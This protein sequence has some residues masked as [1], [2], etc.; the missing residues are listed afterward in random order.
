MIRSLLN[1]K[2]LPVLMALMLSVSGWSQGNFRQGVKQGQIKVK[3]A[4]DMSSTLSQTTVN[5]RTGGFTTGIQALDQVARNTRARTMYRLFPY[6]PRFEHKLRKHGL[7]LW[8]IVE[9]DESVD[10]RT[11]VAQF[12]QLHEVTLAEVEHEK[13]LAPYTVKAYTPGTSTLSALPFNDPLLKDQWHYNNIG[14][15][16]FSDAD[17][18]LFEAWQQTTGA[19]NIVVSVHDEGVDVNHADLKAN[20]W[21]NTAELNGQPGV[22]DDGNGYKDDINGYNFEKN[23]GAIDAQ[24][25]GTHVAGTIAAVNNNGLGVSGVAGGNGTGNGVKIMSLQILGGAPIERSY[26]YAAN[27]GAVISQNSWGYTVPGYF[28]ESVKEAID[29]FIAEAGDY[30]GSPMRGGIVLFAAGNSDYDADWYPGYYESTFTIA[31][32]GPEWKRAYYSNYGSWVEL[33]APG[34]DQE[35]GTKNGVLSTIP[36]DQYAYLQGTSMACPHVSGIAALALANRTKQL[37]NTE[38]WNKL[39]TGV[40]SIDAYNPDYLGKLGAGAIDAALAIR[41]DAGMA[42]AAIENLE[43]AGIAQ[44]FAQLAWSVPA[45]EDDGTPLSFTIHY[46]TQPLT[47]SNLNTATRIQLN[48]TSSVGARIEYELGNLLGLT[49]YYFAVTA[50]DR[51]GNTSLISNVATATT[52]EGPSLVLQEDSREINFEIDASVNTQAQALITIRN[53]AA[54]ILRWNHFMRHKNATAAFAA[55]LQYPVVT[56]SNKQPNVG[57]I[58]VRTQSED[59]TPAVTTTSFNPLEKSLASWPTN[60]VGE[61]NLSLPNSAAAKFFVSETEGF[62]LT[63]VRMYLKHDPAKGPVIVEVYKGESPVRTNLLYAQEYSS[64]DSNEAWATINLDEQLYFENGSTFWIAFHVPA[65]NL[66]PLGI[67]YENDPAYSSYCYMSFDVGATWSPLEELLNDKN[68]AWTMVAASN[69]AYLGEYMT[70][71]PGSGD[72][73][74][75]EQGTTTLSVDASSLVNGSYQANVVITSNDALNREV[76]IPVNVTVTGHQPKLQYLDIADFG[77]V[78]V[79]TEKTL[80]LDIE[81]TG[82]GNFNDAVFSTNGTLFTID[83]SPWR[84]EARETETVRITFRPETPGNIND[85]LTITNGVDTYSIALFGVGAETATLSITPE[86]QTIPGIAIGDAVSAA[87]TVEN[88]G[89]YPLKYFVPGFD[90][91]GVSNNWPSSYHTYG[92]KFRTNYAAETNPLTYAFQDISATGIDITSQ[93]IQND[94]YATLDLGFAFPY[95]GTAQ[96]KIYV[97]QKGFTTF[98]NSVRPINVPVLGNFYSPAGY[99]SLLGTFLTYINQGKIY[100]Q[101]E[102]DRF[103]IQYDNVTD[104]YSGSITAQMV[105]YANGDIRFFYD[106]VALESWALPYLIV[107]IEDVAKTDG[108]MVHNWEKPIDIYSGLALGFDYPGPNIIT[109]IDNGSGIVMPGNSVTMTVNMSTG[110][111]VEGDINRYVNIISNDPAHAQQAALITLQITEGGTAGPQYSDEAINFGTVF[112]GAVRQHTLT[113]KNNGSADVN[114]TGMPIT[115]SLFTISGETTTSI[116][117]GLYKQYVIQLPTSALGMRADVL[118]IQFAD[119]SSHTIPLSGE[120]VVPPAISVDLSPIEESVAYGET[121]SLPFSITNTGL[122]NLEVSPTGTS[123][124]RF[125]SAQAPTGFTYAIEKHN[126]GSR[127]QWLDIRKTGTQLPFLDFEDMST[128]WR[129]LELPFPI[130]FYGETYTSLKIGDNGIISFEAEP[131]TT[132]FTDYIPSDIHPGPCIMPYWTFSGFSDYLYPIEDIGIFY[133][134]YD[135]KIVI[136]WSYFVNNFGGMGDPVS[137]QIII[138]KDGTMKLQYRAEEGGTDLTS[139]FSTIGLQKNNS[140]GIAISEYLQLDYGNGLAY[141][142]IPSNQYIITPGSTLSGNIILDATNVYGGVYQADLKLENNAPNQE[143]LVKPATLTVTGD[144]VFAAAGEVDFGSHMVVMESG[145]PASH[146]VDTNIANEGSAP[147]II[148]FIGMADGTQGLSL[149]I[150]MLADGWFGPEWRWVD[151]AEAY[152]PWVWPTPV[153]TVNPGEYLQAR[154]VFAPSAA[155]NFAD[156]VVFNTNIGEQRITVKGTA[157]SPPALEVD[158]TPIEVT[159]NETTDTEERTIVISNMNGASPLTYEVSIDFGRAETTRVKETMATSVNSSML[160]KTDAS[161]RASVNAVTAYNSV[162][163]HTEATTPVSFVGTGGAAPFT[164][165]TQYNAGPQGFNLSHVAIFLRRESTTEMSIPVEIRA[166][167]SLATATLLAS[168][169]LSVSGTGNDEQ[170]D[171]YTLALDEA[172]GIYPNENFFVVVTHPFGVQFPQG[173]ITDANTVPG[174]YL[175]SDEGAWNDLNDVSEFASAGWLMYVAEQ[176]AGN[177]SWITITSGGSGTVQPGETANLTVL[178]EGPFAKRGDQVANLIIRSNDPANDSTGVVAKLH[179]NEAPA[180]LHVPEVIYIPEGESSTVTYSVVDAEDHDFTLVPKAAYENVTHQFEGETL[181]VTMTPS[182][183]D[184]GE[185]NYTFTATDEF[186]AVADILLHVVVL[187]TNRAPAYVREAEEAHYTATGELIE[188]GIDE[189]FVDPDGDDITFTVGVAANHVVQVFVAEQGFLLKPSQVGTT[190]LSFSVQDSEGAVTTRSVPVEVGAVLGLEEQDVN[191]HLSMYPNPAQD[192]L[193]LTL[194]GEAARKVNVS[195]INSLGVPVA[196]GDYVRTDEP[197]MLDVA[198]L[199]AGIYLVKVTDNKGQSMRRLVKQ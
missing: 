110:S 169:T 148:D 16:G 186:G 197:L 42:P 130:Q 72:I 71:T 6:D 117:P 25:H 172:A 64:W 182:Y 112:Q 175:Y 76:R 74:G 17:V 149:Q 127:Y 137:A 50:T 151:I 140:E 170:G 84:I 52:N 85:V 165:A 44:E 5:A 124:M 155:G 144:A 176:T 87:I 68:F 29:Y 164:L 82:F 143:H 10:P 26:I 152:S 135:D 56:S 24:Y 99:I 162:I 150:Y 19:N 138:Y 128:F 102:A 166:G 109:S 177:T 36:K 118:T 8:Y 188:Y 181:T 116:K 86:Q 21:V 65:G 173:I 125:E 194:T 41:N 160:K 101:A 119:G 45:D 126:D 39:I 193:Q 134:F 81:N 73:A 54:G 55:S 198:A 103:I 183:D 15:T 97:A 139:H 104:G 123:W 142:I 156:E 146:T 63:Q 59:Q 129:T 48:N 28:D 79:G 98:D 141:M 153:F 23:K 91:K 189:W 161:P 9:I 33:S 80:E 11:A 62:N 61:T 147:L 96:D 113:I 1:S 163:S 40:V 92:Y 171:W 67:G 105:L 192:V 199:P 180:A 90:T 77:A 2:L 46:H 133:Q 35:Y 49:T 168:G 13:V 187:N 43:V 107:L 58:A 178:M 157:I 31:A 111:L 57:R 47:A 27:N 196:T 132:L 131:E 114:I 195:L 51:W 88:Q 78:F 12:R 106:N 93:L 60:I 94:A 95:Y 115:N 185:Y 18:N 20:I 70:L 174:R 167:S 89:A 66:Y 190:A 3:F 179:M 120:V 53:E 7:H 34:G 30:E 100:Y 191:F 154:A 69:N 32:L 38:L 83:E 22:D 145:L 122:A 4:T 158:T 108:I 121:K 75:L 184:A 37:T 136:L 159:M 14:Q